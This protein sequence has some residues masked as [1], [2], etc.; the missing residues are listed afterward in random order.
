MP[1]M[2][3]SLCLIPSLSH[4]LPHAAVSP[5]AT[6]RTPGEVRRQWKSSQLVLKG[7][8]PV[9]SWCRKVTASRPN[10]KNVVK[11]REEREGKHKVSYSPEH[12][13]L[14]GPCWLVPCCSDLLLSIWPARHWSPCL[15]VSQHSWAGRLGNG[16]R[17]GCVFS[18]SGAKRKEELK[19]VKSYW[20]ANCS[21]THTRPQPDPEYQRHSGSN[22]KL[23]IHH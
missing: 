18:S 8:T 11:A 15:C 23:L 21:L 10:H 2:L 13:S 20:N 14:P 6:T 3:P 12:H 4:H 5:T 7:S 16:K 17:A 22:G 9:S 19:V 1:K